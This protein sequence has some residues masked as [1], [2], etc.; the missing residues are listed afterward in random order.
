[1]RNLLIILFSFLIASC[2]MSNKNTKG[3]NEG[4]GEG[5][6][7]GNG[8]S[9][10]QDSI[11]IYFDSIP[12][13]DVYGESMDPKNVELTSEEML[14]PEHN[15]SVNHGNLKIV[16]IRNTKVISKSTEMSDGRVVYKIPERMKIRST[17]QVLLRISKSK[18]IL[19]IY[20]SLAGTVRT[21][22]I[23]VT[24][25]MKASLIDPS[26]EDSKSFLI[27]P[28]NQA[29]QVVD[30]GE[31]YT[32]WTWNV[33]PIK[34]GKS[35][36]EIVVSTVRNGIPKDV[37][38]HDVVKVDVDIPMQLLFFW[39]KYWQWI[40]GTFILPFILWFYKRRKDKE[41]NNKV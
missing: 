21:S 9:L 18:A 10:H 36:I 27:V 12:S 33:T 24:Q 8:G 20:D 4:Y 19:S 16:T 13:D 29:I 26:P 17:Y 22:E 5:S 40:I 25:T 28:D 11:A 31:T 34:I 23:P 1:M 39:N 41:K 14:H 15:A 7:S 32:E 35:K 3:M 2:G 37:V 30:S 38:Y 6:T